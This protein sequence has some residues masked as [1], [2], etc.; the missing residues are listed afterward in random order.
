MPERERTDYHDRRSDGRANETR[1]ALIRALSG[2]ATAVDGRW[3]GNDMPDLHR[4]R[5][6]LASAVVAVVFG[7]LTIFSGAAA[8]FGGAE[9]GDV[10]P[11][12]LWFNFLA[13][14]AYVVAGIG[15]WRGADWG[16]WLS[17]LIA[18][19]TAVVFLAFLAHALLENPYEMRTLGAMILRLIVWI[20]IAFTAHRARVTG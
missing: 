3:K 2:H 19:A 1:R 5:L 4:S 15:L 14:F 6:L 16:R 17:I 8:L 18:G 13:G 7:L 9:M 12:V 11:F 20:A 10:V